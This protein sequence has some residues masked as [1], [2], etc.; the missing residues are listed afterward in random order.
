MQMS[1]GSNAIDASFELETV[2]GSQTV[3][4]HSRSGNPVRNAHYNEG[5]ELLLE[6]LGKLGAFLT[7]AAVD[8]ADT[9][10]AN[11]PYEQRW[12]DPGIGRSYPIDL[13]KDPNLAELR[14]ALGRSQAKVGRPVTASGSG[15]YTKQIRLFVSIDRAMPNDITLAQALAAGTLLPD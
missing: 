1:R 14:L 7:A 4:F 6:R 10:R 11:L 5:L 3:V 15:N 12:L 9:R 2:D 8:S 13:A